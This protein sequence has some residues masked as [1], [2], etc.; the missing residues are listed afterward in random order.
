MKI[1]NSKFKIQNFGSFLRKLLFKTFAFLIVLL[2]FN[3]LL[4]TFPIYA[5]DN[6]CPSNPGGGF[7]IGGCFGFGNIT[8][9]GQAVSQLIPAVFS[10]AAVAV[11][12]NFLLGAFKYLKAGSSKEEIDG[13]RQMITHS[14]IGFIILIFAF[15]I[16]QFLLSSLFGIKG[17]Q[18]IQG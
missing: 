9:L 13:A 7:R 14:I 15:L 3:F 1:Q 2:T 12:I 18:I 10:L 6:P 8:S 16:L 5:A 11:V 17:F 4:L